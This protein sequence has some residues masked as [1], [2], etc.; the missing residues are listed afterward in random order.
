VTLTDS[1]FNKVVLDEEKDVLVEFYAPWCGHCKSLAPV[2]ESVAKTFANDK[3]VVVAKIDAEA[4]TTV[5]QN[6]G[7]SS[8]PQLKFFP[9]GSKKEPVNYEK[10]R[11][12]KDFIDFLNENAGTS[13]VLGGGLSD[14]AGRILDLDELATKLA[15]ATSKA[16]EGEVYTELEQVLGKITSNDAKYYAKV[17][18]KLKADP[19]YPTNEKHRLEAIVAKG[20]VA[21]EKLDNFKTRMNILS[22]FA[23]SGKGTKH[24][25]L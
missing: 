5:A 4:E 25:E 13:R 1:T 2:W 6:Y 23:I 18:E 24:E 9:K 8:Y 20:N 22:A 14:N 12:E 3:D 17:F 10:G 15:A 16:E 7:I 19:Q 21:S 11:T